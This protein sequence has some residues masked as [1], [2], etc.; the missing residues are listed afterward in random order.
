MSILEAAPVQPIA[1]ADD[2]EIARLHAAFAVQ[3][4]AFA[5]DRD[6]SLAKRHE[7]LG[8]LIGMIAGEP[9]ADRRR[10]GGGFRRA[11]PAPASDLIESAG[12][13]RARALCDGASRERGCARTRATWTPGC[14][15]AATAHVQYQP[16]GVDRQ[17]RPLELPVRPRRRTDGRD[18]GGR[19]PGDSS[20]RRSIRQPARDLLAEMMAAAF[21]PGLVTVRGGRARPGARLLVRSPG[22]IC[23]TPAVP[24]VGRLVMAG[25]RRQPDAGDAGTGRQMPGDPRRRAR[26]TR[27]NVESVI[28]T[29]IIKNGQMCVTVDLLPGPTRRES[30]ASWSERA[31]FMARVAPGYSR[32]RR[33]HGHHLGPPSRP[34]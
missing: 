12:R 14:S 19:Q 30:R 33:L 34:R 27:P 6:P 18:A 28:G 5:A 25:R 8:A 31:A 15:A 4:A 2:D 17:Y 26:S 23:C 22:T 21:D 3:R 32:W 11:P 7:R 29:K 16:K 13:R 20:S 24:I 10:D 9:R 1:S